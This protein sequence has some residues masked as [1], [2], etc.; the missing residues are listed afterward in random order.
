MRAMGILDV[1][2]M[3]LTLVIASKNESLLP[4]SCTGWR[5]NGDICKMSSDCKSCV[6]TDNHCAPSGDCEGQRSDGETCKSSQDCKSCNCTMNKCE[7]NESPAPTPSPTPQPVS[8]CGKPPSIQHADFVLTEA[9]TLK[10]WSP[11]VMLDGFT[12]E[13]RAEWVVKN[14]GLPPDEAKFFVMREFPDSFGNISNANVT[15]GEQLLY[16]CANGY[17]HASQCGSGTFEQ[18]VDYSLPNDENIPASSQYNKVHGE[19]TW[20][21]VD[22]DGSTFYWGNVESTEACCR[23]CVG[24]PTCKSFSYNTDP[25]VDFEPDSG[26]GFKACYLKSGD[27]PNRQIKYGVTSGS[28][29]G[30]VSVTCGADGKFTQ[31]TTCST[32]ISSLVDLIV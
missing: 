9:Y 20:K 21:N 13:D 14:K 15:V 22:P 31:S 5:E 26:S 18:Q 28:T 29:T 8:T 2:I 32:L 12:A 4:M 10:S 16:F 27:R 7:P 30:S 1:F 19:S 17:T 23:L 3:P 6:C 11:K 25:A 24:V